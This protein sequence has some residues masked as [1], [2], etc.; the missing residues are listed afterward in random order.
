MRCAQA[1]GTGDPTWAGMVAGS[2]T[3][4]SAPLASMNVGTVPVGPRQASRRESLRS[5]LN[6]SSSPPAGVRARAEGDKRWHGASHVGSPHSLTLIMEVA[7]AL[8]CD[9]HAAQQS[10]ASNNLLLLPLCLHGACP[11]H[12]RCQLTVHAQPLACTVHVACSKRGQPSRWMPVPWSACPCPARSRS[13]HLPVRDRRLKD[14]PHHRQ[15]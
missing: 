7:Q 10:Q 3:A 13:P 6:M 12:N 2:G 1:P 4:S 14:S 8:G 5:W 9:G 11:L 15:P